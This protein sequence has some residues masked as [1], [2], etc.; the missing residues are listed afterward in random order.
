MKPDMIGDLKKKAFA[1]RLQPF[2]QICHIAVFTNWRTTFSYT[3]MMGGGA[4]LTTFST[5]YDGM[6]FHKD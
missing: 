1:R 2:L 4:V 6:Q 5:L 3:C